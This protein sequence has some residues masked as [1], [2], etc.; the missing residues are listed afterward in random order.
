MSKDHWLAMATKEISWKAEFA[1]QEGS[2]VFEVDNCR[3]GK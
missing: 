1:I 3:F 2:F